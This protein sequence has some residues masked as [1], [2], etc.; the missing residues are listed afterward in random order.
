MIHL[1]NIILYAILGLTG[2]FTVQHSILI[3]K[4]KGLRVLMYHKIESKFPPDFLTVTTYQL[5]KQFK[6]LQE[7]QYN[8][9]SMQDLID[10]Q[11]FQK[12]LP[13]NPFILTFDDGYQ[14]NF[15]QLY[16]LL[17]KYNFKAV[18]FLVGD[19]INK[20]EL[21]EAG[22]R[23]YLSTEEINQMDPAVVEFALHSFDHKSY[24]DLSVEEIDADI[25]ASKQ[26]LQNLGIKYLPCHAY[27]YGA[28]PKKDATKRNQLFM[29]LSKHNIEVAFR[30]GNRIN[31]LPLENPY[32][33]Q[34]IDI[35]GSDSFFQFRAKLRTGRAKLFS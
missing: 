34:R 12:P 25:L 24:N 29:L 1:N 14:N 35:R 5:E 28:F 20:S 32:L 33:V 19:F 6:I 9:I 15:S 18:I 11:L 13:S 3:P 21:N 4:L 10:Y 27:T 22:E 23:L 2:F 30:I 16:P 17:L 8:C 7:K 26:T 31:K